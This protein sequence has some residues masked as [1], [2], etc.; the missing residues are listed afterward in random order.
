MA[1]THMSIT[2]KTNQRIISA[3]IHWKAVKPSPT[4]HSYF[5][6]CTQLPVLLEPSLYSS[7]FTHGT[8]SVTI[9]VFSF[10]V[11]S[12]EKTELHE[13]NHAINTRRMKI[14]FFIIL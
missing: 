7:H 5:L 10:R 9:T 3:M 14:V 11:V 1:R 2:T 6:F 13:H 8:F 4:V 12:V